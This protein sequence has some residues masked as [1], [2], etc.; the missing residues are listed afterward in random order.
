LIIKDLL[1]LK[2]LIIMS[3]YYYFYFRFF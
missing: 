3:K 1:Q 2:Y